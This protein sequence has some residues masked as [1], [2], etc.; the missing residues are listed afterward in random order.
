MYLSNGQLS[1]CGIPWQDLITYRV[2]EL[3][4]IKLH[5]A[6]IGSGKLSPFAFRIMAANSVT[7]RLG[8]LCGGIFIDEKFE[9]MCKKRLGMRWSNLTHAGVKEMTKAEW[10]GYIKRSYTGKDLNKEYIVAIPAEA[11]KD[12]DMTDLSRKPVIIDGRFYFSS[13]CV[14]CCSRTS[15]TYA[16]ADQRL[17]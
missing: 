17:I 1:D 2:G 7:C 11:F 14:P 8:G 4:P 12:S 6:V 10:E 3:D 16:S 15:M 5:E 13:Y 9:Y